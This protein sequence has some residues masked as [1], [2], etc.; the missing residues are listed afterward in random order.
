MA[1]DKYMTDA[2][3]VLMNLAIIE[4]NA[5]VIAALAIKPVMLG[6]Q[7]HGANQ[8]YMSMSLT[9]LLCA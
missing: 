7:Q 9:P 2:V 8:V 4:D 3:R 1:D 6:I 5:A